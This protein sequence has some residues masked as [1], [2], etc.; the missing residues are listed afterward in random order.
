MSALGLLAFGAAASPT[1]FALIP[2]RGFTASSWHLNKTLFGVGLPL[3]AGA[4]F[5][6]YGAVA[7]SKNA[8]GFGVGLVLGAL[9]T[10]Q[11]A[12]K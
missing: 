9:A 10:R 8:S 4:L 1:A 3:A 5:T 7:A 6:A 11:F 12:L 2:P